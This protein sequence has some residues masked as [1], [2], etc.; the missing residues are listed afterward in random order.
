MSRPSRTKHRP[1]WVSL[2]GSKTLRQCDLFEV[3]DK[4]AMIAS[5]SALPHAFDLFLTLNGK[6]GRSCRVTSRSGNE[7]WV[8]F[9]MVG[10]SVRSQSRDAE[11]SET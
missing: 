1:C 5:S 4:G 3:S 2:S 9:L 8:E 11:K 10:N 6:V 7:V